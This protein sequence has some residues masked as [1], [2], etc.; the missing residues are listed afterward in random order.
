MDKIIYSPRL[1]LILHSVQFKDGLFFF[2]PS[3]PVGVSNHDY[4]L[5]NSLIEQFG[6]QAK[7]MAVINGN[8]KFGPHYFHFNIPLKM[9]F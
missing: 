8:I 3:F 2:S 9:H 1:Q 7:F 6:V 5:L 4:F